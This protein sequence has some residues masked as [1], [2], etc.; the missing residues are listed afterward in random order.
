MVPEARSIWAALE[1]RMPMM[2]R[3]VEPL[4]DAQLRWIPGPGRKPIAW[5][6]WHIAEVEDNWIRSCLLA[7]QP[8]FPLGRPLAEAT[9][10]PPGERLLAYLA[11]VRAL[12]RVRL[13]AMH[14]DDFDGLVHDPDFG[15]ITAR[16]LW[17]GVVTSFA[18]HAG[19]IALTAKLM[20]DSPITTW[21]FTGWEDPTRA[22]RPE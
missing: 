5:Q 3:N 20:P 22:A 11:D 12:S 7:E 17:A 9:D 14:E 6:L 16:D 19:Q 2:R 18:W 21:T 4:S 8:A 13:D 1:F 15:D 10:Y